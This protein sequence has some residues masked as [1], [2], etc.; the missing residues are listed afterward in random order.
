M[1]R[2]FKDTYA[3][4]KPYESW[5]NSVRINL[6]D[7]KLH[8][9]TLN[10]IKTQTSAENTRASLLDRQQHLATPGRRQGMMSPMALNAEEATGSMGNDSPPAVMSG[11]AQNRCIT[12]SRDVLRK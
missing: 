9:T 1:T 2:K 8:E 7:I 11:Q 10:D 12:T 4:A 6:D 3:N 5:I